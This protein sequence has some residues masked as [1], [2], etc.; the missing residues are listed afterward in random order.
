MSDLPF[1]ARSL[2]NH[3]HRDFTV[4]APVEQALDSACIAVVAALFSSPMAGC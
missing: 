1:I 2:W 4:K 3:D